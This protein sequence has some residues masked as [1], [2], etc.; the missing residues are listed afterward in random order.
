LKDD[1]HIAAQLPHLASARRQHIVPIENDFARRWF[2]GINLTPC[3]EFT[4]GI[5]S[6]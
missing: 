5:V 3:L 4:F 1:L 2:S 6:I